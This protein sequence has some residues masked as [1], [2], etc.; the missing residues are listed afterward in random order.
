[1]KKSE[2]SLLRAAGLIAA[3]TIVSKL[4]GAVRDWQIV[5]VYGASMVS[6]AYLAAA[7]LPSFAIVLLGG[8]GGPFHTATVAIFTSLIPKDSI[9]A[10][11]TAQKLASVFMTLTAIAGLV[12]SLGVTFF[13]LPLMQI[14][15]PGAD[16][17]L[18]SSAAAQL[19]IMS[20]VILIGSLVGIF[21]GLLNVYQSFLWPS[22]SPAILNITMIL[23][24]CLSPH[25]PTGQILAWA[26]LG[27]AFGQFLCQL[28]EFFRRGFS[29]K[30]SFAWRDTPEMK[31]LGEILF[32]A[33]VG[34][35]IGQ[36]ITYVDMF[37]T[38]MLPVGGWTAVTLSNRLLQLPIG[39]LQTALLV[40]I[41]P[42]FTRC[43]ADQDWDELRRL[44]KLGVISLWFISI[45]MLVIMLMYGENTIRIIFQHGEFTSGATQMVTLALVF[46]AFQMLP[47]F[48][49]DTLTRVFYAFGD[50]KTPLTVGLIAIGLKA[51]LDWWLIGPFGVGGITLATTLITTINMLI[52]SLMMRKHFA[53]LRMHQLI[54]AFGKLLVAGILMGGCILLLQQ[55]ETTLLGLPLNAKLPVWQEIGRLTLNSLL[56]LGAYLAGCW[57]L[58]I[59][60]TSY[61]FE[62]LSFLS[63]M[64]NRTKEN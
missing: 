44:F 12:L 33:I 10:P 24:L 36:L 43:V 29:L 8:L 37:F 51:L 50:A 39:V 59:P 13:S 32:P 5:H 45:P 62:R 47:Y 49:R 60:E 35:T 40:P 61:L 17:T 4:L 58:R 31:Q 56:S 16:V 25:D 28:P 20:P 7:Q 3:V 11:E 23:T 54:P 6:D 30:P 63:F 46:Q 57:L 38:S 19:Q 41:F 64:P 22:L 34:T 52:L 2:P 26:T 9:R 18:I 48:A 53:H 15:L 27:G 21:Y 1:M 14:L 42:R 55:V